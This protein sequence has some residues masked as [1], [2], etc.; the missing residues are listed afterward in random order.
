MKILSVASGT[1][2]FCEK[3]KDEIVEVEMEN[4]RKSKL[5]YRDLQKIVRLNLKEAERAPA[6]R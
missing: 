2:D 5:C 4:G 6:S 3:Q 1:C